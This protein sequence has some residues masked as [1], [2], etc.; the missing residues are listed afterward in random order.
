MVNVSVSRCNIL[1]STLEIYANDF[2]HSGLH[3][4]FAGEY[5]EDIE[6]LRREMFALFWESCQYSEQE[7]KLSVQKLKSGSNLVPS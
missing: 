3:I 2:A 1:Q 6:R 4:T 7:H 5:G